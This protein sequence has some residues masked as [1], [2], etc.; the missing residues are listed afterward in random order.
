[1]SD[2]HLARFILL[3]TLAAGEFLLLLA[4]LTVLAGIAGH[5][6]SGGRGMDPVVSRLIAS[7]PSVVFATLVVGSPLLLLRLA[8]ADRSSGW[9]APVFAGGACAESYVLALVLSVSAAGSILM[10]AGLGAFHTLS[11][12][13]ET[14]TLVEMLTGGLSLV[15]LCGYAALLWVLM[16]EYFHSVLAMIAL[17]IAPLAL[18]FYMIVTRGLEHPPLWLKFLLYLVPPIR[19]STETGPALVQAAY[20]AL[21]M[22]LLVILSPRRIPVW[23]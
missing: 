13:L 11:G 23:R 21:V 22:A 10:A 8:S 4:C 5:A 17:W 2:R 3:R 14:R 20:L 18:S 9:T 12:E 15:V 16:Y 19:R 1:M 7:V 6:I